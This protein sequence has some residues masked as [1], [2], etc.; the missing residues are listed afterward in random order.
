M[1]A[2]SC[3]HLDLFGGDL[4]LTKKVKNMRADLIKFQ[5]VFETSNVFHRSVRCTMKVL[6]LM[7][8]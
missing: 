1:N 2:V 5:A 3:S 7:N 4:I 8:V 6:L